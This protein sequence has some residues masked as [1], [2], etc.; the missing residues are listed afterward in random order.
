MELEICHDIIDG[1][2][3]CN[4]CYS[5]HEEPATHQNLNFLYS[6][7]VT[8]LKARMGQTD[9]RTYGNGVDRIIIESQTALPK[10][11]E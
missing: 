8:E 2:L 6:S 1:R 11:N 9:R 4:D 5:Y 10:H 3:K 7:Y